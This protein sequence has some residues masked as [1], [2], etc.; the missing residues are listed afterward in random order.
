M[1]G[2]PAQ[3]TLRSSLQTPTM[4]SLWNIYL[5]LPL[6]LLLSLHATTLT[7]ED[8]KETN[9]DTGV[10]FLTQ[11]LRRP[12]VSAGNP[13][14]G[15]ENADF[16]GP[17]LSWPLSSFEDTDRQGV[18]GEYSDIQESTEASLLHSNE[19][20]LIISRLTGSAT[21]DTT[22]KERVQTTW[23]TGSSPP[24][25]TQE[26]TLKYASPETNTASEE[27]Q[28]TFPTLKNEMTDNQLPSLLSGSLPSD[29]PEQ[30]TTSP[31][32]PGPGPGPERPTPPAATDIW[33]WTTAISVTTQGKGNA[34]DGIIS[35][36]EPGDGRTDN[37]DRV[38]HRGSVGN[39]AEK[40]ERRK[41]N[42]FRACFVS[43]FTV[44]HCGV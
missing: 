26:Q 43:P 15:S 30:N 2:Q 3:V 44:F 35:V 24:E 42:G 19:K 41:C 9:T 4:V 5:L 36:K 20:G 32:S 12:H 13:V 40:G 25:P 29:T 16:L 11:P 33:L 23:S 18:I 37:A 34:Q 6:S 22:S 1:T 10:Q 21:Q 38:L 31:L 17:P 28:P 14:F 8:V 27:N 7:G 39:E